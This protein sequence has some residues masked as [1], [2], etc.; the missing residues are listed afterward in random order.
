MYGQ[1]ASL[2]FVLNN[3]VI[4]LTLNNKTTLTFSCLH[5]HNHSPTNTSNLPHLH[6]QHPNHTK[7]K[8]PSPPDQNLMLSSACSTHH[9]LAPSTR[10][11][12]P[13]HRLFNSLHLHRPCRT[14]PK[15]AHN[16]GDTLGG[17]DDDAHSQQQPQHQQQQAKSRWQSLKAMVKSQGPGAFFA[18]ITVSNLLSVGT[19]CSAWVLFT[20]QTG[21]TPLQAWPQ[22]RAATPAVANLPCKC[23]A[24][25]QERFAQLT[26][27][28]V[29]HAWA[30]RH[31]T[32]MCSR[33]CCCCCCFHF[34]QFLACYAGVYAAQHLARPYKIAA[35]LAAAPLGTAAVSAAG[36]M[37]RV[38]QT[39]SLVVL[40]VVEAVALLSCLG[41]VVLYA[42]RLVA[43][44]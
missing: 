30:C 14:G 34:R 28:S 32:H 9:S 16:S 36:R 11:H 24:G 15:A 37:L 22:V 35:G 41:V 6:Q 27:C 21:Q 29:T 1:C 8:H 42:S 10:I 2:S 12:M 7:K 43:A 31:R 44:G 5:I 33:T 26:L 13:C 18:Y 3:S 39:T 19:M 40:L 23:C 4:M 38:S 17:Q 25:R 20:R